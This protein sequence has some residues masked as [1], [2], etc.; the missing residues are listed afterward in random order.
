M[1]KGLLAALLLLSACQVLEGSGYRVTEVQF[2]FP[3][4]TERWTYFYGEP[5]VVE[6]DGRPLRLEA[7]QGEN[8]WAFPG[9]LWVEGSP[10]LRAT[11]PS[12]P[13][14][15]EAVRGVSGS[16]LQVRAQ[17]PLL[18]T[19]L[20]DGV[21][22]VR[23][24]GSLREGEERTLVQPANYQTPRLFPLTEEESAVVLREVLARRGGKPVVV[25]E[26][27]EPPLPPLRLSP[28]PDA[29]RIARLQVQYGLR[30]EPVMPPAPI[31]RVLGQGTQAAY[32]EE[33]P[34]ALLA[35]DPTSFNRLWALAV[36][37]QLPRPAA[38][39][40]DFRNRS[41]A[42]FFWGLKPTGG[43]GL[44]VVGVA[45]AGERARVVLS[46]SAPKPGAIT[47][48]ALTSPY[49]VLELQK[50]R[51]VVFADTSGKV[52]AEARD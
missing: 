45:Y 12:R 17:A 1:R 27:R 39:A 8:L 44:K 2:L 15:A 48:Q 35:N 4:A 49:V 24:T 13:P 47:T 34:L 36:G 10:V 5:R 46:L 28:A 41:V 29:Y 14:V 30:L 23:L 32:Q 3:E 7:P 21:G 40:V 22:W 16:L 25:F 19:W 31:F 52:L 51:R 11:Y 9:A 18:A 50:V 43:Y 6:L 37:N 42:A 20:Y 26:L 38:P 33:A